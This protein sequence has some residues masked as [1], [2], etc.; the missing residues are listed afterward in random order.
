MPFVFFLYFAFDM[1][2][3]FV[4]YVNPFVWGGGFSL[5]L[6]GLAC[7]NH[8]VGSMQ[9]VDPMVQHSSHTKVDWQGPIICSVL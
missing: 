1:F 2:P 6:C 5:N 4:R 3:L 9:C 7:M 8:I